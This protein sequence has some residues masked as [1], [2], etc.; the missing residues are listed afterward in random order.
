[1]MYSVVMLMAM[2]TATE[3][4]SCGRSYYYGCHGCYGWNYGCGGYYGGYVRYRG[5]GCY[6]YRYYAPTYYYYGQTVVTPQVIV[7]QP[8]NAPAAATI[9]VSLPADAKLFV[10]G[11]QTTSQGANRSLETPPLQRD[12]DFTYTLTA[13]V[14]RNNQEVKI[15]KQVSVSAG[16]T[17]LVS[18]DLTPEVV[19]K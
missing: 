7:A 17:S 8:S 16:R 1:M 12:K 19:Q 18:F 4:P 11:Q 9:Q 15:D 3:T 10:D 5:C 14:M 2:T 6:G 13:T